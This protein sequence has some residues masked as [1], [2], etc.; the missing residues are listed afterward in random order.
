MNRRLL[1]ATVVAV[2]AGSL[3]CTGLLGGVANAATPDHQVATYSKGAYSVEETIT[4]NTDQDWTYDSADSQSSGNGGH[5]ANQPQ[6]TLRAHT[7]EVVSSYSNDPVVPMDLIV[8]YTMPG[9]PVGFEYIQ[10]DVNESFTGATFNDCAVFTQKV[11]NPL[12]VDQNYVTT[13]TTT[14]GFHTEA[15]FAIAPKA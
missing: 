12:Y 3:A 11:G 9:G 8:T 4:N 5:W 2:P 13:A 7:S 6:Q 14:S 1:I 10:S 15:T